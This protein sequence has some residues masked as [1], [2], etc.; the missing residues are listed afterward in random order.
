MD[1]LYTKAHIREALDPR[2]RRRRRTCS[3]WRGARPRSSRGARRFPARRTPAAVLVP[4][5]EHDSGLTV[6]L[7]QR[8]KH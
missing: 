5:V 8:A 2:R 3:G 7:T 6:L 4:L 1:S